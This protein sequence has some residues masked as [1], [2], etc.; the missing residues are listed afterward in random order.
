[1]LDIWHINLDQDVMSLPQVL[2][3][4][5]QARAENFHFE[6]HRRRFIVSHIATRLILASYTALGPA[7]L[8]FKYNAYGKPFLAIHN[9][10]LFNISHTEEMALCAVSDVAELGV[11]IEKT[12][13]INY[14]EVAKRFFSAKECEL[15]A[16]LAPN[17]QQEGFFCCWTRKEA[18]IKAKGLGLSLPLDQFS[19]SLTPGNPAT[20]LSS[21]FD[22][23]D[24]SRFRIVNIEVEKGYKAALAYSSLTQQDPVHYQWMVGK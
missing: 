11:D 20:L 21:E 14:Y 12:Q 5:E 3:D 2:D 10:L 23:E 4:E 9:P 17:L 24:V 13:P 18:Y 7:E 19:V 1:M 22:P 15:L 8:L 6:H 16:N